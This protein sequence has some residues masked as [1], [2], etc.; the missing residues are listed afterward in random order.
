M[1]IAALGASM[2]AGVGP[3]DCLL[4]GFIAYWIGKLLTA[5]W[6]IFF[7]IRVEKSDDQQPQ[8]VEQRADEEKI[9]A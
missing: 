9:A 6:Y 1:A 7:T 5:F 4:R 3:F 8:P 2:L